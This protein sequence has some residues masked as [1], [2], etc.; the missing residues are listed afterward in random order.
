M[1]ILKIYSH[2]CL[3]ALRA[4]TSRCYA[5]KVAQYLSSIWVLL[6]LWQSETGGFIK[7][8]VWQ[9]QAGRTG[10]AGRLSL[11]PRLLLLVLILNRTVAWP[12]NTF[13][14]TLS[15]IFNSIQL[16]WIFRKG[17]VEWLNLNLF[18]VYILSFIFEVCFA[19]CSPN[20]GV[21]RSLGIVKHLENSNKILHMHHRF[22][23]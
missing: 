17:W 8:G 18:A 7:R 11:E 4:P 6:M 14:L 13:K 2:R 10:H 9:L 19:N 1:Y 12:W 16:F 22:E 21:L 15:S 3:G 20:H 5:C 23:L